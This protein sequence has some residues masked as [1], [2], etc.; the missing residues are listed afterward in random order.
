MERKMMS[1]QEVSEFVG[2][3]IPTIYDMVRMSE[4]PHRRIRSRIMF[5]KDTIDAW[6]RGKCNETT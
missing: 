6:L 5:H 4:I 2:V 3:S 1:V